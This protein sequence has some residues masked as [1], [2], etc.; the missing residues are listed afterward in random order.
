MPANLSKDK[1]ICRIDG[2]LEIWA[3]KNQYILRKDRNRNKDWFYPDLE[4][5]IQ[6]IFELKVKE[7]AVSAEGK[8]L[9]SLGEAIRRAEE[10]IRNTLRP[11]LN[12][13][14]EVAQKSERA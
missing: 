2:N 7:Y 8:S 6:D 5:V 12:G 9:K 1:F 14:K 11:I 3:D 10:Y 4:M 13:Y